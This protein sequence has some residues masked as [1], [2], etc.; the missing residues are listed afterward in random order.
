MCAHRQEARG[1]TGQTA[2]SRQTRQQTDQI[3]QQSREAE[4]RAERAKDTYA[5]KGEAAAEVRFHVAQARGGGLEGGVAGFN[6]GVTYWPV[7]LSTQLRN[8]SVFSLEFSVLQHG[9]V[10]LLKRA[11]VCSAVPHLLYQ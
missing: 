10:P 1:G 8:V 5:A 2:D 4:R 7:G 6:F 3:D 9:V 11:V